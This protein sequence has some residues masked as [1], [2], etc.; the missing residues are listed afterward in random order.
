MAAELD[1][2]G[3]STRGRRAPRLRAWH[4][5]PLL[6]F[7]AILIA[8][9]GPLPGRR[10]ELLWLTD[11]RTRPLEPRLSVPAADVHRPYVRPREERPSI[12]VPLRELA[13]LEESG[14]RAGIAASYLLHGDPQQGLAHLAHAPPSLNRDN[15][16]AVAAFL[17]KRNDEALTWLDGLLET[18][19]RHPQALWNRALV[20]REMGLHL[21][22]ASVFDEVAALGEPGWSAEAR[23]HASWLRASVSQRAESWNGTRTALTQ[24]AQDANLPI[25]LEEARRHPGISRGLFYD[26]VRTAP[27][28]ARVQA[29]LPLAE[30]LD[31][32]HGGTA[33]A[34]HTRN[35][36][37][38]DFTRRAPLAAEYARLLRE[39]QPASPDY[40]T[41]LRGAGEHDLLLGARLLTP[42][43]QSPPEELERV[44]RQW[45]DP[46]I[47]LLVQDE[48]ARQEGLAGEAW[49][50]D[51]R[52]KAALTL[53]R[54]KR[55][56]PRCA[57]LLRKVSHRAT[58][59]NRLSEAEDTGR[60]S[61]REAQAMGEWELE[62]A[63]LR[64][65]AQAARFQF[66]VAS[67]RA[68]LSEYLARAPDTC[69]V[70]NYVHRN[71][72]AL[73]LMRLRPKEARRALSRAQE[74]NP[75]VGLIGAWTLTDLMRLDPRPEDAEQI[76]AELTRAHATRETPGRRMLAQL[77]QARFELL[78]DRKQGNARLAAVIRQAAPYLNTDADAR[79]TV[80]V[81]YQTMAVTAGEAGAFSEVPGVVAD[82]LGVASPKQCALIAAAEAERTVV[83]ALG[84]RGQ[85]LG[86]HDAS[87]K[88]PLGDDLSGLVPE[89]LLTLL[90][91]CPRVE[92]LAAPPL[93]SR[94]GLLPP[95][96]AWS[97]RVAMDASPEPK[98]KPPPPLHVVVA[99]VETPSGLGLARLSSWES[100]PAPI[101]QSMELSGA[102]ATPSRVLEAMSRA[103]D[104]EF[105]AHGVVDRSLS[106]APVI[107]LAPE[108]D[109][110]YAL[111][112][113]A[114]KQVRLEG[115]PVVLLGACSAARL[116]PFLHQTSSLPQA[117]VGAGARAVFAATV[118]I[119]DSAG[120]FFQGV[121]ERIHAG[122]TPAVALRAERLRWLRDVKGAPWVTRVL[123]YE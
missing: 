49:Q 78:K 22:A 41:R 38:R 72:A 104:I 16:Q 17:L 5:I 6:V 67:A 103:T 45:N 112:S 90:R 69:D 119:P 64:A 23:E 76:S 100:T 102:Q 85:V 8:R 111:T 21:L 3:K 52:L 12:A 50:A 88:E 99:N 101:G 40:L 89:K 93:D 115:S 82:H 9:S 18:S 58:S 123:L 11:T 77:V 20:L 98:R 28:S 44:A 74:C 59:A 79:D 42:E 13:R 61:W 117:F 10:D 34:D 48:L 113:E 62:S 2:P 120:R 118:D 14:D 106:E 30:L 37:T 19:P 24:L 15:D 51:Q 122:A 26:V 107:A 32:I 31:R 95:E 43:A 60:A 75:S 39:R 86:H 36:A 110:R 80:A 70:K 68:Y 109:G 71:I 56:R 46:W 94:S 83:V 73:E 84:P 57:D 116:P 108:Y 25:P 97:Y 7:P 96:M 63:A 91:S 33:L 87:R 55:L 29:L 27:T 65:L 1:A 47:H 81:A 121:R 35:I 92:V 4:L 114:L 105:H 54:E 66:R 53:C